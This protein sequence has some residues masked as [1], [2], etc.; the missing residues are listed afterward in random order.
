MNRPGGFLRSWNAL[1]FRKT[2]SAN[3]Q[4]DSLDGLRGV[5]VL[6]VVLSHFSGQGVWVGLDLAGSGHYGVYL[7]FVLSA[8]L[9]SFQLLELEP[10]ALLEG[11][12][13][14]RYGVRRVLRIFPLYVTVLVST[15]LI[16]TQYR[17]PYFLP[18]PG[19]QLFE[20]LTLQAGK[21][22]YW[23]IPVE[24]KYYLVL[25]LVVL[26]IVVGLRRRA[27]L[28]LP[29]AG[30]AILAAAWLWPRDPVGDRVALKPYLP[31]FLSGSLAAFLQH[32]LERAGGLRRVSGRAALEVLAVLCA[33]VVIALVPHAF[34]ALSG[35]PVGR[36]AF[37]G[38]VLLFGG[39]WSIFLLA[40]L[41]GSG[42]VRWVLETRPLRFLGIVSFSMYLW[43]L[44]TVWVTTRWLRL[45]G[46]A[47]LLVGLLLATAVATASYVLVERPFL[48]SA[49]A[50]RLGGGRRDL[51]P[52]AP[53]LGDQT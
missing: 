15:H 2:S 3:L 52:R 37:H 53:A 24:F 42:G 41:N 10:H 50:L 30:A 18:M 4:L 7:F 22:I 25:P 51:P 19:R 16:W 39:L 12:R 43:H 36:D 21:V 48:R 9:L 45:E 33:G 20:H 29:L 35:E 31:I 1:F 47:G 8:F 46:A 13:W 17:S 26:A 23:T 28:V 44:P 27:R 5:A 32:R 34:A 6:L 14:L 38:R 11:G 49:W 40:M